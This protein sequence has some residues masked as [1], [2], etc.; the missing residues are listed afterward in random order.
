M[1]NA[2]T[3]RSTK[4][5]SGRNVSD[6]LEIIGRHQGIRGT[7]LVTHEVSELPTRR[8]HRERH[9]ARRQRRGCRDDRPRS[10]SQGDLFI[11]EFSRAIM[12][13]I[14]KKCGTRD[15]WEDWAT[16]IA[17]IAQRHI[18]RITGHL[19][20][21][22]T[23]ARKAF[24]DFSRSF[25]T[26]STTASPNRTHRDA[27]PAPHHASV[28]QTLFEGHQFV[29][30][31]P[32][33]RVLQQFLRCCWREPLEKSPKTSRFSRSVKIQVTCTHPPAKQPPDRRALDEFFRNAFPR[34]TKREV[35]SSTPGRDVCFF[36][37]SSTR[38]C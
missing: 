26:T 38:C 36:L 24:D 34:T 17:E 23:L 21:P 13:K 3:G 2:S 29:G 15:Y 18:S 32:V 31:D 11:D 20:E 14:V 37:H 33:S 16:N 22:A 5:R 25:K 6:R 8:A 9:R 35:A 12:A 30:P 28:F 4:P 10:K 19:A 1:T 27:G 7:A